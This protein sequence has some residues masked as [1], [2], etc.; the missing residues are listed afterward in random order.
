MASRR[1]ITQTANVLIINPGL[2]KYPKNR[3][4]WNS[5]GWLPREIGVTLESGNLIC[6]EAEQLRPFRNYRAT[7]IY[8]LV[9]LVVDI[10]SVERQKRHLISFIDGLLRY[11]SL[12][13]YAADFTKWPYHDKPL[14]NSPSGTSSMI[15][16]SDQSASRKH[17]AFHRLGK[18]PYCL[19]ISAR[20][21]DT[22]SMSHGKS[23]WTSIACTTTAL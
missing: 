9:G 5:P 23:I 1:T 22:I 21:L 11:L 16:W 3:N 4:L 20:K 8:E 2:E 14:S 13:Q 18:P 19:P 7:S 12:W 15:S 6:N 17:S 10:K